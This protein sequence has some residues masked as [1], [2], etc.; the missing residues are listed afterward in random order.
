M[1]GEQVLVVEDNDKNMKLVLKP[2]QASGY[3]T[4]EA[5]GRTGGRAR[6]RA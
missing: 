3:S 6:P 1:A 2:L 5:N 4:I